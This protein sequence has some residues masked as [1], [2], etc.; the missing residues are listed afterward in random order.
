ML[1]RARP[2]QEKSPQVAQ[3]QSVEKQPV[4]GAEKET[5]ATI[6]SAL[7]GGPGLAAL[8]AKMVPSNLSS[9]P[10]KDDFLKVLKVFTENEGATT[11]EDALHGKS[12]DAEALLKTA[13]ATLTEELEAKEAEEA[14]GKSLKALG[15]KTIPTPPNGDC[16]FHALLHAEGRAGW[17]QQ[18]LASTLRKK[19]LQT[20][21]DEKNKDAV[22]RLMFSNH[23]ATDPADI[24]RLKKE[25]KDSLSAGIEQPVRGKALGTEGVVGLYAIEANCPVT[26]LSGKFAITYHP[27]GSKTE[28]ESPH[29][30]LDERSVIVAHHQHRQHF[31]ATQPDRAAHARAAARE[32]IKAAYRTLDLDPN[33]A[34]D[35]RSL[36]NALRA[37]LDHAKGGEW[38]NLREAIDRAYK[39]LGVSLAVTRMNKGIHHAY[40]QAYNAV[41]PQYP[42]EELE[43]AERAL[44]DELH[45][46]Q[47]NRDPDKTSVAASKVQMARERLRAAQHVINNQ[48]MHE[49]PRWQ[50]YEREWAKLPSGLQEPSRELSDAMRALEVAWHKH[51]EIG[52]TFPAN[53]QIFGNDSLPLKQNL[54]NLTT[55]L[56][57]AHVSLVFDNTVK[58]AN[59]ENVD[60]MQLL[61]NEG[62]NLARG[63]IKL[64][65]NLVNYLENLPLVDPRKR[66]ARED[67]LSAL[68][69]LQAAMKAPDGVVQRMI[70]YFEEC[71]NHPKEVSDLIRT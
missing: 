29:I 43:S 9:G 47:A 5:L 1:L 40:A 11:I 62:A 12:I 69:D 60:H 61:G 21:D 17:D 22:A 56:T 52:E 53:R 63:K 70:D 3:P 48:L 33:Q 68:K 44:A 51:S 42:Q 16:L 35:R 59:D 39:L 71:A 2:E 19:L 66:N 20:I 18:V 23:Q 64:V 36:D 38:R 46:Q 32:A 57:G 10:H 4:A 14:L 27:D 8:I 6:A 54:G 41:L 67:L 49:L 30:K 37:K 34:L 58:A 24:E 13:V 15:R 7:P 45:D 55:A 26:V 65:D 28:E 50:K 25:L 31:E